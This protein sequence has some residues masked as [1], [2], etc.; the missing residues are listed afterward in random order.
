MVAWDLAEFDPAV[1]LDQFPPWEEARAETVAD[2]PL[3]DRLAAAGIVGRFKKWTFDTFP[4]HAGAGKAL[5][6][7]KEYAANATPQPPGLLLVGPIG[8]G[9]TSLAVS[10]AQARIEAGDGGFWG[11]SFAVSSLGRTARGEG[12][13]KPAPVWFESFADLKARFK[14]EMWD[15]TDEG[16]LLE[17]IAGV[18]LLALDEIGIGGFTEW[19][20]EVMWE[21]LGRVEKGRRLVLTS[22]LGPADLI[23]MIGERCADRLSDPETFRVVAVSGQSLRQRN[24]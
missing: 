5:K 15:G 21:I 24:R 2:L 11:W 12:W 6:A 18:N 10:V 4:R 19:R 1:N 8:T 17:E 23:P 3:E 14:R 9:K 7:A 13:R 16:E 22:N 20:E